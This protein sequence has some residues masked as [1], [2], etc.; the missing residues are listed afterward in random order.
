M[1]TDHASSDRRYLTTMGMNAYT[2]QREQQVRT[3][4]ALPG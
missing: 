3:W 4:V 1:P 2:N